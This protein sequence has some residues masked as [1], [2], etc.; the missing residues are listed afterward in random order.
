MASVQIKIDPFKVQKAGDT[1]KSHAAKMFTSLN[2]I[3]SIVNNTKSYFQS[4]GGDA[5][6][7]NFNESAA[8]FDE[9]K[10]FIDEYGQFLESYGGGQ[11]KLDN[12]VASLGASIPK[13]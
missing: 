6:R 2:E 7:N 11:E 9:F 8:K 12:K 5:T 1:I 10:K 13:L 3:K 4:E